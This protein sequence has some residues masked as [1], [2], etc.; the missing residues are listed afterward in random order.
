MFG[1]TS[2]RIG[3]YLIDIAL[4]FVVLAPLGQL[5]LRLLNRSLR[6]GPEIRL[7][8]LVNFSLPSWLSFILGARSAGGATLGKRCL[9]LRV[10]G[11]TGPVTAP[12]AIIRSAV[13]LL[14]W[15][16]VH[17]SVFVAYRSNSDGST[18]CSGSGSVPPISSRLPT[19]SSPSPPEGAA[20]SMTSSPA[21]RSRSSPMSRLHTVAVTDS[22]GGSRDTSDG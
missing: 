14:P 16:L 11:D 17:L 8:I 7:T 19:R 13:L 10:A 3:A 21:P 20:A 15:E 22:V 5:V 9:S 12:Q 18:R 2:R 1:R 4:L 6:T